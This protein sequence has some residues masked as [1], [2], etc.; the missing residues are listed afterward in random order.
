VNA[1][2]LAG[3]RCI[4]VLCK[5]FQALPAAKSVDDYEALLPWR[6]KPAA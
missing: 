3:R 5:L 2:V 4:G 1:G 6:L